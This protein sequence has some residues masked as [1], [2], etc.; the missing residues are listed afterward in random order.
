M[1]SIAWPLCNSRATCWLCCDQRS[2]EL[3][4]G[5]LCHLSAFTLI[6][7][8][9]SVLIGFWWNGK[10][11]MRAGV[12]QIKLIRLIMLIDPRCSKNTPLLFQ[13]IGS[14][15]FFLLIYLVTWFY[16]WM[17]TWEEPKACQWSVGEAER[18]S[19]SATVLPGLWWG[20][21][22]MLISCCILFLYNSFKN[23]FS[24]FEVTF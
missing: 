23:F 6:V 11:D 8:S 20:L 3:I 14:C 17:K 7:S 1:Q 10:S 5:E 9:L 4:L 24:D 16:V 22:M 2:A 13:P 12:T 19:A 18:C 15:F 21:L